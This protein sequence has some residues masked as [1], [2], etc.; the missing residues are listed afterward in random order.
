MQSHAIAAQDIAAGIAAVREAAD[1]FP[2]RSVHV[3]V[4]DFR[5]ATSRRIVAAKIAVR[6]LCFPINGLLS[7]MSSDGWSVFESLRPADLSM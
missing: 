7:Q 5:V 1:C 2:P 4:V 3:A 6:L